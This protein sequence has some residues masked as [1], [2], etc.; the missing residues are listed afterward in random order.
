M[1]VFNASFEKKT[2][3][4]TVFPENTSLHPLKAMTM[5]TPQP[6]QPIDVNSTIV[7]P[8]ADNQIEAYDDGL[9]IDM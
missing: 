2:V 3:A 1:R 9:C 8:L 6:L 7:T 4:L 5:S